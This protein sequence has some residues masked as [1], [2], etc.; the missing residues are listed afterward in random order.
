M[1]R[2]DLENIQRYLEEAIR[3][4]PNQSLLHQNMGVVLK[5]RGK[6]EEALASFE[7]V[8]VLEPGHEFAF[9][10]KGTVLEAL[11][12]MDEAVAAYRQG[13]R[14]FPEAEAAANDPHSPPMVRSLV[15][16][17]AA[18]VQTSQLRSIHSFLVP[19]LERHGKDALDRVIQA[20]DIAVGHRRPNFRH[21][22]QRPS[23]IYLPGL[24][25]RAFFDREQ[26]GW[27]AGLESATAVIRGE[28]EAALAA[29]QG[30]APYVQVPKGQEPQQWRELDG[31]RT[32]SAL[33]LY[34]A[35]IRMDENCARCPQS[36]RVAES[37]ELPL[38]PGHSPEALFSVL[39]PGTHIPPHFGLGNYKL[40]AHL[41]LIVPPDCAIRV[42]N[43][44]RGWIEGEC[45]VFDDSFQH[46]AW[47][48][49]T[50]TRAVLILDVW[51]PQV[52]PAEREGITAL[53]QGVAAFQ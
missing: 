19:V 37:L 14:N 25:P 47:N 7:R 46:E 48:R 30:F 39:Q 10:H 21:A 20:A 8:T 24:E 52:T 49:S 29:D 28:L 17:A 31:S 45:L 32:W 42:G 35:G 50:A 16:Q 51:H 53:I 36:A 1:E 6:L 9:L 26:F 44:T 3:S 2:N 33:H 41:P 4:A 27:T 23:F 22:L 34:K 15:M 38:I 43:E 5:H 18:A 13:F 40:V 12:R 11:G